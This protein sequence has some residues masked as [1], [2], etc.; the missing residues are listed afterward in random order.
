MVVITVCSPFPGKEG[1]HLLI[2]KRLLLQRVDRLPKDASEAVE[3]ISLLSG[4]IQMGATG[5]N[6]KEINLN[7]IKV[8]PA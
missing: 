7:L 2:Q 6:L 1:V 3:E 8:S 4:Q 5:A